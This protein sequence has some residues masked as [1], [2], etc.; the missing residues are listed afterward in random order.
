MGRKSAK[1]RVKSSQRAHVKSACQQPYRQS[2]V[3]PCCKP[4][5]AARVPSSN[6]D[7]E[8]DVVGHRI[9]HGGHK[10]DESTLVRRK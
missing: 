1:I 6:A 9:V 2:A 3:E 5:G 10:L 4:C 8:I 7:A